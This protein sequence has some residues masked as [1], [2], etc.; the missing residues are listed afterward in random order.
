VA[1]DD[2][3]RQAQELLIELRTLREE[4]EVRGSQWEQMRQRFENLCASI[5]FLLT[6]YIGTES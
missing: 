5:D 2:A 6:V 4:W 1:D 3:L